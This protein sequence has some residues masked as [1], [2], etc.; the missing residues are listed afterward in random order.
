MG[1]NELLKILRPHIIE[2]HLSDFQGKTAAVD[3]MAWIYRGAYASAVDVNQGKKSD[4]YLNFPMKM[5]ALLHSHGITPIAVFDG[6]SLKAKENIESERLENKNKNLSQAK[7]LQAE[8]K[9]E[10]SKKVFRRALKIKSRMINTLIHLLKSLNIRVIVAPYEA[11]SQIAYLCKSKIADFAITEDS[12]LIPF[13]VDHIC[14]KL[15]A[16]GNFSYLN[17]E[18]FYS[19]KIE[20]IYDSN[21]R[22]LKKIFN[23]HLR[24]VE[25]CVMLGCDYLPSIKGYGFKTA[26][27]LFESYEKLDTVLHQM[28]FTDKFKKN[29]PEDYHVK[30]KKCVALFFLQTVY[31]PQENKL[32]PLTDLDEEEKNLQNKKREINFSNSTGSNGSFPYNRINENIIDW[33]KKI[34]NENNCEEFFGDLLWDKAIDFCNGNLDVKTYMLEKKIENQE[35]IT[36][37]FNRFKNVFN[38]RHEQNE[39][40]GNNNFNDFNKVN[41]FQEQILQEE[42]E[43]VNSNFTCNN[44]YD[45]QGV[46]VTEELEQIIYFKDFNENNENYENCENRDKYYNTKKFEKNGEIREDINNYELEDNKNSLY[47]NSNN[48]INKLNQ[49]FKNEN[50]EKSSNINKSNQTFSNDE[51]DLEMQYCL[52]KI[53]KMEKTDNLNKSEKKEKLNYTHINQNTPTR[54]NN[55]KEISNILKLCESLTKEEQEYEKEK[56]KVLNDTINNYDNKNLKN[57]SNFNTPIKNSVCELFSSS[58]KIKSPIFMEEDEKPRDLFDLL[59][60]E[61]DNT[62]IDHGSKIN[63]TDFLR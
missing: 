41:N 46:K 10:E 55:D 12:D 56:L 19:M 57:K 40:L 7:K 50:Y 63:E 11:D 14:Y 53:S 17:M 23:N 61:K 9:E 47:L 43:N 8:G 54:N 28:K 30:V 13:G 26:L 37:Y 35:S 21:L 24:L 4:L 25:F 6:R 31:N 51:E 49:H 62:L 58:K 60:K 44:D 42:Q 16:E 1:I 59:E 18:K 3:M 38:P 32:Q 45:A 15:D 2:K 36:K 5:L 33:L 20:E 22:T 34:S 29:M 48:N 27:N 52:K 39:E